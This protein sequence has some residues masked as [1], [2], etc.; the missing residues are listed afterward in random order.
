MNKIEEHI[1][2]LYDSLSDGESQPIS[3]ESVKTAIRY[4]DDFHLSDNG[5]LLIIVSA[6]NLL[7][8]AVKKDN[9]KSTLY[10]SYIKSNVSKVAEFFLSNQ[11]IFQSCSV[12]YDPKIRNN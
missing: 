12:Y 4:I 6:L 7:N 8:A 11:N 2:Q 10:Y 9:L 1:S 3:E 5:S